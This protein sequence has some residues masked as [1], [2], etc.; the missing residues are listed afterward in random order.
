MSQNRPKYKIKRIDGSNHLEVTRTILEDK[1]ILSKSMIWKLQ[2]DFYS[3]QGPD[4]W[5]KGIV[6]QYITTNPY[7]ANLYA[8]ITFSYCRDIVSSKD[9]DPNTT[10]YIL[11]LAAGVGRFTYTFL[12]RF[13]NLVEHSSLK[14]LKFKYIVSDFAERNV[15]YWLNHSYLKPFFDKGILDCATFDMTC[16]VD[17]QLRFSG[18][19]LN[20]GT[21]KNP[22][23]LFANYT[24]D[25][26][27]QDTF[28]VNKGKLYEGLI[29]ITSKGEEIDPMD[30]SILAGLDYSYTDKEINGNGYYEDPHVNNILLSYKNTLEDTAFSFPIIATRCINRLRELFGDD[31]VLISTDKGYRNITSMDKSYHPFLSKHGSISLTVNFH[32]LELYFNA[33]GGKAIHSIYNHENVTMSLFMFTKHAHDFIETSLAFNEIIEHIGPDDFFVLKKALVPK[34]SA[35][36][37]KELLTFLR[38]THWDA[39][40]FLEFY[41]TLLE[42]ISSEKDFPKEELVDAIHK[43]LE[44]Y[45]PIGEE[46]NLLYCFANLLGYFGHDQDALRLLLSSLDF[47]PEDA[48]I[49]Y[50][51]ALC[52]YNLGEFNKSMEYLDK[53]LCLD[54]EFKESTN[55]KQ[56]IGELL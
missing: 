38:Y 37:T 39:R 45:F 30:K 13:L 16:D 44:H 10:I 55:L 27:P 11:E 32:A 51:I 46:G 19:L 8:K 25:S 41:N 36:T 43:V 21:L 14:G 20:P 15:S 1:K 29:T 50:E 33:L 42:R 7:I 53:S 28:Y 6:P 24:F 9:F 23:I 12:N 47:Y 3:K 54:S 52:Y 22:L 56:L 48:V 5:M 49:D 18:E 17:L 4:A 31:M 40:T 34:N 35:L 26:L 2:A